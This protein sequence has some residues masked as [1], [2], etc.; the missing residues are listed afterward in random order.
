VA[1]TITGQDY[2]SGKAERLA[3]L[4][5]EGMGRE[6]ALEYVQSGKRR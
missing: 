3:R 2:R 6:E 4:G 1:E 5:L